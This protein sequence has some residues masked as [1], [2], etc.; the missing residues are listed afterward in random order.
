[1]ASQ[2]LIRGI[3]VTLY[4]LFVLL[5]A[6]VGIWN[7]QAVQSCHELYDE[8]QTVV[9]ECEDSFTD[10]VRALSI[11]G[12]GTGGVGLALVLYRQYN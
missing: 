10:I 12:I 9:V 3:L 11:L 5:G 4:L 7:Y 1:M 2:G 6:G 8:D